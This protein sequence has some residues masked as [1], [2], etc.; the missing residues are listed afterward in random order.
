MGVGQIIK[1]FVYKG[2]HLQYLFGESGSGKSFVAIDM[3]LSIAY[4][5]EKWFFDKR[6]IQGKVIYFCREG[7]NGVRK[8]IRAW[9]IGFFKAVFVLRKRVMIWTR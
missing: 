2:P 5:L 8:K 6:I 1:D 9:N 3:G 4:G 7:V